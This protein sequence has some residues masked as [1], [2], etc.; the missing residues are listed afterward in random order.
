MRLY[1][2]MQH[3][4][5]V[6][7]KQPAMPFVRPS[8]LRMPSNVLDKVA[9]V[10]ARFVASFEELQEQVH[11]ELPE[12]ER[13]QGFYGNPAL[14]DADT[15]Y[16]IQLQSAVDLCDRIDDLKAFAAFDRA[17]LYSQKAAQ[18]AMQRRERN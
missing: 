11:R 15:M 9:Y 16:T 17:E 14:F 6:E 13:L 7:S 18:G 2:L 4:A 12:Y 3:R 1:E 8:S 10:A 5:A